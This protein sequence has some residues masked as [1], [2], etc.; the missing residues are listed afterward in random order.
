MTSTAPPPGPLVLVVEDEPS[1]ASILTAYLEREGLRARQTGD[2]TTALQLFRQLR[3]DLVLLDIHLPGIDGLDLLRAIRED[4]QTPVI[5]VTALADDVD[6]LLGLRMG[7]DDYVVK[8]FSPPEVVAR[9]R[10]VLRRAAPQ[11]AA[12]GTASI[13]VGRIEIDHRAHEALAHEPDGRTVPLPLTLTEFRLLACL[14]AQPRR[15]FSRSHL[16]EHCLP[17]SDALDRV[18]D[19]HLSKLRRKLQQAGQGDLIETVRGIGYRLLPGDA[20]SA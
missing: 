18:I 1:I 16:I 14:A 5:M 19:S 4:G 13:R 17:E 20:L 10:A 11:A 15:C 8:P 9:V 6:K 2:G 12:K 3:P 7:A